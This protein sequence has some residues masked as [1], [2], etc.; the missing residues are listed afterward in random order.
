MSSSDDPT[1]QPA[2]ESAEQ[3]AV[4]PAEQP[5]VSLHTG[6]LPS[7]DT[8]ELG[9]REALRKGDWPRAG[10]L[11]REFSAPQ[12]ERFL[13]RTDPKGA[14]VVFRLLDKDVAV[15]VF[16][17]IEPRQ[18]RDLIEGL[19]DDDVQELFGQLQAPGQAR[20]LDEMPAEVAQQLLASLPGSQRAS[21]GTVLGY[22]AG[23]VG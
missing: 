20:L 19:Q 9:V 7:L 14:P 23:S 22:P 13:D 16:A 8:Q 21:A 18:Q 10:A 3:P 17:A 5:T 15:E 11:L 2:G 1:G 6:A 4:Q 12:V